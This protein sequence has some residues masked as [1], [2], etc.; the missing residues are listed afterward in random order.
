MQSTPKYHHDYGM[1]AE[2][3]EKA[4]QVLQEVNE[5]ARRHENKQKLQE[6]SRLVDLEGLEVSH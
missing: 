2:A 1:V 3:I 4:E 5:A 6:L